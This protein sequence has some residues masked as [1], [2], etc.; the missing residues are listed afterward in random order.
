MKAAIFFDGSKHEKDVRTAHAGICKKWCE[1][2]FKNDLCKFHLEMSTLP[3]WNE[4]VKEQKEKSI[5]NLQLNL[6]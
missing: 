5:I 2:T 4:L 3:E 6:F 1:V